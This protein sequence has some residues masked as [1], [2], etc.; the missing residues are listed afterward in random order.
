MS[1]TIQ[2][3]RSMAE[4]GEP[5]AVLTAYDFAAARLVDAAGVHIIL[6][7]DSLGNTV[8][9]YASTIP[10]TME[11][12]LRH[13]A[14]VVRGARNALVVGDM[15]FMSFQESED[16]AVHNAG[17]FLKET[18]CQAV[19]MEGGRSVAE[20]IH[21][22]VGFGIPVMAHIGLTPQSTHQMGGYHIQGRTA[23]QA[24]ALLADAL[25]VQ[26]AGA[27]SV[28]LEYVAAPVAKLI[29]DRLEIPTI[30]IGSGPHCDGQVLVFHD[31][32]GIDPGYRAKHAKRY[33][34]LGDT[35][36]RAVEAYVE[37]VRTRAFPAAAQSFAMSPGEEE[38]LASL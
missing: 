37:D 4:R 5:I 10:V 26:D 38:Q 9:G 11:D 18:G 35:I 28:V 2:H 15:P 21:R 25:A 23:E 14:A 36:Q 8:L 20:L 27:F 16:L 34:D 3:I 19:K 12:M 7:G 24:K 17:R 33:A 29:S 32:L 22:L 6:V 13:T 1:I 30:G 31:M